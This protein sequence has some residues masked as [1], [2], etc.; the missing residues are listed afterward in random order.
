MIPLIN[1]ILENQH[2]CVQDSYM[3]TAED[4]ATI[5]HTGAYVWEY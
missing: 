3:K 1:I 4:Q 5:L 2:L